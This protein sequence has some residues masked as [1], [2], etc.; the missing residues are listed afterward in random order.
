MLRMFKQHH[1]RREE[2]LCGLWEMER[3]GADA[4]STYVPG[5]WEHIPGMESYRGEVVYRKRFHGGGNLRLVFKGV[6]HT[7]T[8]WLDGEEIGKHYNA[9]TPFS[10]VAPGASDG[11]HLLEVRVD[12]RF[13][14]ESALH[15]PND[16]MTYGGITRG[17]AVQ[18]VSD[19]YLDY[20]HFTPSMRDGS[21]YGKV[22]IAVVNLAKSPRTFSLR[23][24]L[25]GE[26]IDIAPQ[27]IDSSGST[28]ITVE[29]AFPQAHAY[30]QQEPTLYLLK[31]ELLESG[32]PVDDL[33]ERVGFREIHIREGQILLNGKPVYIKGFNRHE[34]HGLFGCAIPVEA[35]DRDLRLLTDL[36]ANAVRTAHYPNDELFLDLCDERGILVWEESHARGLQLAQMQNPYF[37]KQSAQCIHE[38]ITNH[39]NHPSI[40]I[41]GIL[42]ECA[43]N[44]DEGRSCYEKQYAQIRAMDPSRPVTSATCYPAK[45]WMGGDIPTLA[46]GFHDGDICLDL[47]DIVSFNLYPGWYFDED[48]LSHIQKVYQGVQR[49][50]G[51]GK[52]FLISEIGAG[53][54]YGCHSHTRDKW[55]EERQRDILKAQLEAVF[56]QEENSGVFLWQFCDGR[57]SSECFYGRPR[58]MNNKGIVD[59]YR[60][61]KLAYETVRELFR[62]TKR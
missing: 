58:T 49:T 59:E 29:R 41:W 14:P 45:A 27:E 17:V 16:Y 54:I 1:I 23:L 38:M 13:S 51:A 4:L 22:S 31:T 47:C 7:A 15:V 24:S 19:V 36:G 35:M 52:P 42:N 33:V 2:D 6:S 55:T 48:C 18:A 62:Q 9:Y 46:P 5:C 30:S 34:D 11:S 25:A 57:V 44:T 40:C 10:F 61:E 12:N 28:T 21:W 39:F 32:L 3:E 26:T 56:A 43:S 60:R 53:A 50:G 20:V 8:V 37:D